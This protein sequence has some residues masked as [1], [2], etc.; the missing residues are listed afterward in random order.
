[1]RLKCVYA[2]KDNRK[3]AETRKP[4]RDGLLTFW[5]AELSAMI[6]IS[7]IWRGMFRMED[8]VLDSVIDARYDLFRKWKV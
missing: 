6:P 5:T 1:M 4:K 7:S 8:E 2:A 3:S